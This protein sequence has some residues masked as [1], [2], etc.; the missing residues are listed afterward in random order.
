MKGLKTSLL[1]VFLLLLALPLAYNRVAHSQVKK[2]PPTGQANVATTDDITPMQC[3]IDS[4]VSPCD[5]CPA[6][7]EAPTGF[8]NKTI[9]ENFVPQAQHDQDR[10]TFEV[11]DQILPDNVQGGGLGPVYNAQ[12]C[13]E[14]HQNPVSGAVSQIA[15]LR[16]GFLD[17]TC[18]ICPPTFS[19]PPGGSLINDRAVDMRVDPTIL[20]ANIQER[21]PPLHSAGLDRPADVTT[22]RTSLNLLGDGLVEAIANQTLL[23]IAAKETNENPNVHGVAIRVPVEENRNGRCRIGRFDSLP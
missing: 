4:E 11:R 13:A 22:T 2:D 18:D 23:D 17:A 16:A 6:P 3:S 14:C 21:V 19:D 7:T 1:G 5:I 9:D 20:Q 10:A 15:E 8:D 12:S